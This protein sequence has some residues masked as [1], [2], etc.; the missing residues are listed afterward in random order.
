MRRSNSSGGWGT[1]G[2][3]VV[4]CQGQEEV[5][6]LA[7]LQS[8]GLLL[9][10]LDG[11][12]HGADLIHQHLALPVSHLPCRILLQLTLL[13]AQLQLLLEQLDLCTPGGS[14][15][16]RSQMHHTVNNASHQQQQQQLRCLSAFICNE[17]MMRCCASE[18]KRS[19]GTC[20]P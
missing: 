7:V 17:S 13:L 8:A 1:W 16:K 2:G 19:R 11:A 12:H 14:A 20:R 5:S 3:P 10:K 18:A 15:V 6:G 4:V 9:V